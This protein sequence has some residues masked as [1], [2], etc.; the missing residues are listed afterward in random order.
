MLRAEEDGIDFLALWGVE[1]DHLAVG[2]EL[3]IELAGIFYIRFPCS[4]EDCESLC[5]DEGVGVD[6]VFSRVSDGIVR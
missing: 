1:C 3:E 2:G 4:P 5:R 6:R